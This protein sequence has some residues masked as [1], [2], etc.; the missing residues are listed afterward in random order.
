MK[1]TQ[2]GQTEV[3]PDEESNVENVCVVSCQ[4]AD[5]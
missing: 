5:I 4:T 2:T 3:P 1:N